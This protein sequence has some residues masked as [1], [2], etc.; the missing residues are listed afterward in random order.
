M[1]KNNTS[2]L[3]IIKKETLLNIKKSDSKIQSCNFSI[4]LDLAIESIYEINI[5]INMIKQEKFKLC[6]YFLNSISSKL[7]VRLIYE[8][9]SKNSALILNRNIPLI[10][11][12]DDFFEISMVEILDINFVINKKTVSFNLLI[13]FL[14]EPKEHIDKLQATSP[15][16]KLDINSTLFDSRIDFI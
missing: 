4:D 16:I 7:D 15:I 13:V 1:I 14:K 8:E 10:F 5:S 11:H 2:I 9:E 3:G 6:D 12:F